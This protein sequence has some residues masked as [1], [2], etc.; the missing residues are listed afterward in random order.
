VLAAHRR[1][2]RPGGRRLRSGRRPARAALSRW[3]SDPA[4]VGRHTLPRWNDTPPSR[5]RWDEDARRRCP[6]R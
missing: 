6:I 5:F 3:R 2:D 4:L 1:R